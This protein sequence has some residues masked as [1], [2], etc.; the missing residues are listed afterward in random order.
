MEFLA[1][2]SPFLNSI[3]EFF[4]A[5]RCKVYD[6]QPHAQMTLLAAMG[7]ACDDITADACRGWIRHSKRFFPR[8]IAGEDIRC[9]V[10]ENLWPNRQERQEL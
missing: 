7:A 10:D 4:S 8:C 6:H 3:E 1:P 5:W 9:D 2:Y